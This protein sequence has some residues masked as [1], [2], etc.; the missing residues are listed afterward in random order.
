MVEMTKDDLN[1]AISRFICEIKKQDGSEYPPKTLYE[2]VVALQ[3]YLDG[4]GKVYKF[5]E[6][7]AFSQ[8]RNT[9]D[10]LMKQRTAA[11]MGSF[12]KKAEPISE[13][14]EEFLWGNGHLGDSSLQR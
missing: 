13:T 1:H 9:L 2:L 12:I 8:I 6:Y 3:M 4:Q 10:T 14:E 11:G 7:P 5:I